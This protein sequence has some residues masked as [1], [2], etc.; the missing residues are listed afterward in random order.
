MHKILKAYPDIRVKVDKEDYNLLSKRKWYL[1][2]N[3]YLRNDSPRNTLLHRL[4]M[5]T[6]K[7]LFTDHINGNKLDNRKYNLRVVTQLINGLNRHKPYGN[8]KEAPGIR[9]CDDKYGKRRKRWAAYIKTNYK[10]ITI[11]Y[12]L[13]REEAL[14]ARKLAVK[15]I[16]CSTK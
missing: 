5:K 1:T 11:G 4:I 14:N 8:R 3:G 7:G 13:T 2:N 16:L 15:E 10:M 9:L 6:P 12:F